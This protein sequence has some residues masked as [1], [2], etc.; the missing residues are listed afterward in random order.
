MSAPGEAGATRQWA[1]PINGI[2]YCVQFSRSLDGSEADRISD[3]I[4]AGRGL[5]GGTEV[6]AEAIRRALAQDGPLNSFM[7]TPHTES[8][9][10]E[11]LAMVLERLEG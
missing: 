6:Y 10:R 1:G 3:M 2:L 8:Q 7:E 11:F 9:L 5:P 4:M